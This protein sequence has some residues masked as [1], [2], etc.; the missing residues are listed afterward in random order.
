MKKILLQDNTVYEFSREGSWKKRYF[1][2]SK[3]NPF[4]FY[5]EFIRNK[6]DEAPQ[7]TF[8]RFEDIPKMIDAL[9]DI[10]K[11]FISSQNDKWQQI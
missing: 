9:L 8:I 4:W 6:K 7:R 5:V 2:V 1:N 11:T 3:R 10:S